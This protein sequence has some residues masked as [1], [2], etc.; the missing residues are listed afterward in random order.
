MEAALW[1]IPATRCKTGIEHAVPLSSA[2]MDILRARRQDG[3]TGYVLPGRREGQPFNGALSAIRRNPRFWPLTLYPWLYLLV[4][5]I[6]NPLIFRWYLTPPL[7]PYFLF[8]LLGAGQIFTALL[9]KI[10][11][12]SLLPY[13]PTASFILVSLLP[14]CSTL[15]EW[16]LHPDHGNVSPAP[17]MAYIKL[18][19]LY[20]QAADQITPLLHPGDRLAAGDV[21]VLGYF[22]NA[23]ILDTVGLNSPESLKYYPEDPANY[24]INYA[25]PARLVNMEQPD[26]VV[27]LEV[28]GRRSL[29]PDPD[30]QKN[31]H[32]LH[33]IPTDMYGSRGMLI[34]QLKWREHSR[35]WIMPF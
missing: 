17:D 9:S 20:K 1:V 24:V 27:I 16:R 31:Y 8:I 22:T 35:Y 21:G 11:N 26:W 14:I 10:Q 15:N 5:A 12:K 6:P 13:I 19:L 30:F 23:S 33:T 4:F 28:Y 18:E 2:V 34:F 3:A 32:L 25:I 7:P 29:L